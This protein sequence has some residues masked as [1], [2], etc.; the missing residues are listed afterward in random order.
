MSPAFNIQH[1][2]RHFQLLCEVSQLV[3]GASSPEEL[4]AQLTEAVRLAL[5]ADVCI[6]RELRG[7][8]LELIGMSGAPSHLIKQTIPSNVGLGHR[9]VEERIPLAI[10]NTDVDPTTARLQGE[11]KRTPRH[12][13]FKSFAG[14][15][16]IV[17]G[18]VVGVIGVFMVN[19]VREFDD[20]ELDHLQ[21]IASQVGVSFL[22]H[23]LYEELRVKNC[24]LLEEAVARERAAAYAQDSLLYDG[25]TGLPRRKLFLEHLQR[26]MQ[27][28]SGERAVHVLYLDCD[29]FNAINQKYGHNAADS[30]LTEI[31]IRLQAFLDE[32]SMVSRIDSD[33]FVIMLEGDRECD[34]MRNWLSALVRE[35]DRVYHVEENEVL[36]SFSIGVCEHAESAIDAEEALRH[37][38]SAMIR[39]KEMGRNQVVHFTQELLRDTTVSLNLEMDIRRAHERGEIKV[40]YQPIWNADTGRVHGLEALARWTHPLRGNIPPSVFI[41]IAEQSGVI[42]ALGWKVFYDAFGDMARWRNEGNT[43]INLYIN[44]SAWQI[45]EDGFTKR[46]AAHLADYGVPGHHVRLEIT[47]SSLL[48]PGSLSHSVIR[49]ITELGVHLVVDDF[50]VGYSSLSYLHRLPVSVLKIDKSFTSRIEEVEGE[51]LI[52]TIVQM[53]ET[54]GLEVVMEGIETTEQ[55]VAC[56]ELGIPWV[57]GFLFGRPVDAKRA[58][59]SFQRQISLPDQP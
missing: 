3:V 4:G 10:V 52:R 30:L 22:N 41:P 17:R 51:R 24:Q 25:L 26:A 31:A 59:E 34:I 56:R 58:L 14:A 57:Q 28:S 1:V 37:S 55:F 5:H 8:G 27:R 23:R 36:V 40:V 6:V 11:A 44:V 46:L 54:L 9:M 32:N 50:G 13:V 47:E 19:E 18:E 53:A 35:L 43:D 33:E 38:H 45:A 20:E 15:P 16:M 21:M 39:A 42:R 7:S 2:E 48:H 12:F 49:E 29:R